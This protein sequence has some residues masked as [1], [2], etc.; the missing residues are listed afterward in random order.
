MWFV[1][2]MI[3]DWTLKSDDDIWCDNDGDTTAS[4]YHCAHLKPNRCLDT[5]P[6]PL[7]SCAEDK[8]FVFFQNIILEWSHFLGVEQNYG[9]INR[10]FTAAERI[11]LG[12]SRVFCA[13]ATHSVP[14]SCLR[15]T[16]RRG[17]CPCACLVCLCACS[18]CSPSRPWSIW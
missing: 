18:P 1:K 7:N 11:G 6:W 10:V 8:F 4:G 16:T 12:I 3:V 17:W 5:D 14:P 15:A 13:S 9:L 2:A